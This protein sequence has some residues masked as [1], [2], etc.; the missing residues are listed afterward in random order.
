MNQVHIYSLKVLRKLYSKIFLVTTKTKP[1]CDQD[2][3]SV[4]QK[5]QEALMANKPFMIA[6]FGST[7]LTCL[8]NYIGIKQQK[9]K[10][11]QFIKGD[12]NPWWW[13][14]KI[15]NQMQQWSGFFPAK[16]D[17]LEQFCELMIDDIPQVD[18]LGS[19]LSD[20]NFLEKELSYTERIRLM[21][22]DPFW[23]RNPWTIALKEK[24]ILVVH[25]FAESIIKQYQ[26]RELLFENQDILPEFKSL[27]VIKAV[28][29]IG[30][31][32]SRFNDW[33]EA[34]EYMKAEISKVDFDIC[35]IGCGA[36]GFPLAAHVKRIGKKA[37][38]MGGSLQLLFGIRGKRWE[39]YD[40]HYEQPGNIFIHYYGLPN[41]YW[42]R[43]SEEEKPVSHSNVEGSCYW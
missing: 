36:Y 27:T 35:L 26:K 9:N 7:E 18:I 21:Y 29:S 14:P 20:E 23:S 17:K 31:A 13:E 38:H 33:F 25:P 6:R 11:S 43:P 41:D 16:T 22:L 8:C 5:I 15:I 19:W 10:V 28:Q 4:S 34:L 3:N 2:P 24:K 30:M 42:I 32:D 39:L 1:E 37:V 40:P 12:S